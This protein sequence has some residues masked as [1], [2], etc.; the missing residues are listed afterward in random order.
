MP[1]PVG[2]DVVRGVALAVD[3]QRR[4][5]AAA[6]VLIDRFI[7]LCIFTLAATLAALFVLIWGHPNG[8]PFEGD[9]RMYMQ[10]IAIGSGLM[11]LAIVTL[12][13]ALLSRRLKE[14][15]DRI[16]LRLPFFSRLSPVWQK[17]AMS[18]N[19]HRMHGWALLRS[20]V[21]STVIVLLT[22]LTLWLIAEAIAP[23]RVS[24][25][26][27]LVVNP[28]IVFALI[29]PLAPGGL[30]IRQITLAYLFLLIGASYDLG[31][32]V[33]LLQQLLAYLVSIPGALLWLIDRKRSQPVTIDS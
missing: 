6:S 16:L 32:A 26:E 25:L 5:D 14:W 23:G 27:I 8:T 21:G 29:V 22:S 20:A 2:G 31:F 30:G 7:G 3:T 18:F 33:G 24:L 9:Q 4:A 11:T 17:L 12:V 19:T 1:G 15:I 10:V 13:C 28:M